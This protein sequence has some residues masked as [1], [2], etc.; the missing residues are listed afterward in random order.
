MSEQVADMQAAGQE[1]YAYRFDRTH[2]S[3]ELQVICNTIQAIC[4]HMVRVNDVSSVT[5]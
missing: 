2:Y 3:A 1:A 5:N 4:S